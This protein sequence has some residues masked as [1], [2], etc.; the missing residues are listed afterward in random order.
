MLFV[1]HS[2]SGK[3][4]K[5]LVAL[6]TVQYVTYCN[7]CIRCDSAVGNVIRFVDG[8]T[9]Q[10]SSIYIYPLQTCATWLKR[11]AR[12]ATGSLDSRISSHNFKSRILHTVLHVDKV[13]AKLV[14][15]RGQ[16]GQSIITRGHK[17]DQTNQ[18]F[19]LTLHKYPLPSS[20]LCS[21]PLVLRQGCDSLGRKKYILTGFGQ[22]YCTL[23]IWREFFTGIASKWLR[24]L[25]PTKNQVKYLLRRCWVLHPSLRLL[26]SPI[27]MMKSALRLMVV[28]MGTMFSGTIMI[29]LQLEIYRYKQQT[30]DRRRRQ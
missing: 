20:T 8:Q 30:K 25:E 24:Q 11:R 10:F 29:L 14:R 18:N 22:I 27:A 13:D 1:I 12:R 15:T 3:K 23:R 9:C 17:T 7:W 28:S 2:W 5:R 6:Y 19:A 26:S 16:S 4:R 21:L